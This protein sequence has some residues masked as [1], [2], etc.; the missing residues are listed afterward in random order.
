M[1]VYSNGVYESFQYIFIT[2]IIISCESFLP[3]ITESLSLVSEW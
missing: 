1:T 2:I 3:A